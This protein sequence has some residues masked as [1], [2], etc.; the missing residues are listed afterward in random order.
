MDG[1]AAGES[2]PM[3]ITGRFDSPVAD[4]C[5]FTDEATQIMPELGETD[6]LFLR[7]NCRAAFVVESATPVEP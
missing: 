6:D 1:V 5:R 4:T 2:Q 7:F 3:R